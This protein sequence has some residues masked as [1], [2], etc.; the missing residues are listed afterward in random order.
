MDIYLYIHKFHQ[1]WTIKHGELDTCTGRPL[2]R[3]IKMPEYRHDAGTN[4]S[5]RHYM[6][7]LAGF[8]RHMWQQRPQSCQADHHAQL[9]CTVP[10]AVMHLDCLLPLSMNL[11]QHQQH[12]SILHKSA[13]IIHSVVT[14]R[15]QNSFI[16]ITPQ[17]VSDNST[18]RLCTQASMK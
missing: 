15:C 3:F 6:Y 9:Q 18:T 4:R 16:Y 1:N 12:L 11:L 14:T 2:G 5:M 10:P 17:K 7:Y 13:T 8:Y